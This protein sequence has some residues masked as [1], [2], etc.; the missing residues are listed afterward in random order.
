MWGE[1]EEEALFVKIRTSDSCAVSTKN[2]LARNITE[3]SAKDVHPNYVFYVAITNDKK[4]ICSFFVCF[5]FHSV[6]LNFI[7]SVYNVAIDI[8]YIQLKP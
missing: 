8:F 6:N 3:F 7:L 4:L 5:R 1:N 2:S